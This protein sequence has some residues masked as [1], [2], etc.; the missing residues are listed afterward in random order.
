MNYKEKKIVFFGTPEF[1]MPTLKKLVDNKYNIIAVVTQSDKKIGRAQTL[2]ETKIKQLAKS[3][4]LE[5]IHDLN[6]LANFLV[7]EKPDLGI[8]VAYGDFL[9]EKILKQFKVG[10]LNLHPSALPKYRGPSPIQTTILNGDK[11]TS[12]TIIKL[13]KDMDHGPIVK[14]KKV[15]LEKYETADS[16]HDKLSIKGAEI[17]IKILPKYLKNNIK[18]K[19]QDHSKATFSKILKREDG[20]INWQQTAEE[21]ERMI[22]AYY[23]WP[24]T[25]FKTIIN[26]QEKNIKIHSASLSK[27]FDSEI[28]KLVN[29]NGQL[30][31]QTK[32]KSI[33]INSL[34]IEGK[35]IMSA[36]EYIN[37]YL[38]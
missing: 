38:K 29:K 5:V 19:E 8:V 33:S 21:I 22:R 20:L 25:Y 11:K 6:K 31:V 1:S 37:G 10:C 14:Q 2:Q 9:S 16:F 17:L 34:Q 23:P 35:N 28:G 36:K 4:N 30:I 15:K 26:N 7:K 18:V 12:V 13:D 27:N 32:D 3:Y 24:G